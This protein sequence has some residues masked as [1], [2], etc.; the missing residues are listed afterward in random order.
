MCSG[1]LGRQHPGSVLNVDTSGAQSSK[2]H[3]PPTP[4]PT[5]APESELLAAVQ[6]E[7]LELAQSHRS[8]DGT[9]CTPRQSYR[10]F[11]P[12][13]KTSFQSGGGRRGGVA[14]YLWAT[15][16][17][18]SH[19][20]IGSASGAGQ[21]TTDGGAWPLGGAWLRE[22]GG[23]GPVSAPPPW[24]SPRPCLA[25]ARHRPALCPP[26]RRAGAGPEPGRPRPRGEY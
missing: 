11:H 23:A 18:H 8:S 10:W 17:L 21:E 20:M 1:A 6:A 16:S 12:A 22:R 26:P 9:A 4:A 19:E 24:D 13:R 14:Y 15:P 3:H 7:G 25:P 5:P 2:A